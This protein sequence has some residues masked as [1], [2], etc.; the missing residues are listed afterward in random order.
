MDESSIKHLSFPLKQTY[1]QTLS[2]HTQR[3]CKNWQMVSW[4]NFN[5]PSLRRRELFQSQHG[6]LQKMKLVP[7]GMAWH[8][9]TF[10]VRVGVPHWGDQCSREVGKILFLCILGPLWLYLLYLNVCAPEVVSAQDLSQGIHS[11]HGYL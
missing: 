8:W 7:P 5:L 6:T 9:H 3:V 2:A 10:C 4:G 1:R 11:N